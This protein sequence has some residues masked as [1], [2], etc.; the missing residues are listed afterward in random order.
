MTPTFCL[1]R[2][3]KIVLLRRRMKKKVRKGKAKGVSIVLDND[4][5]KIHS[6]PR[7]AKKLNNKS[8]DHRVS[9]GIPG[10]D[11]LIEGG[12]PENASVLVCG[13]PGT[14]KT[15]FSEQF[16]VNGATQFKEKG[17]LVSFE[18]TAESIRKQVR[19]FGWDI[20][21]LEKKGLLTIMDILPE[22]LSPKTVDEIKSKI[23]KEGIKRLV[24]DSL[25][26]LIIN[27]P[28]YTNSSEM[29]IQDIAG[30][31]VMLSPPI[32]GEFVTQKFLYSFI[33]K[34]RKVDNC[35]SLLI[36]EADQ[37]GTYISRDTLSE[38][39]C[40]GIVQIKLE[41]LGGSYPRSVSVIKMRHTKT[42]EEAH[43]LEINQDGITI[44]PPN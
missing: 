1:K 13:G 6:K 36:A 12:F 41:Q 2:F 20:E 9:T 11:E 38:F 44:H 26:T 5:P 21:E 16:L 28:I 42:N 32:V 39:A 8:E 22:D 30:D 18:Q 10:F 43:A 23:Q 3:K 17:L 4:K 37:S 27:A 40:D 34:L 33:S 7:A 35:T 14:G 31:N 29:K 15:I 24:V 25:S 19:Q